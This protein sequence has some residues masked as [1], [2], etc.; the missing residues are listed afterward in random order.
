MVSGTWDVVDLTAAVVLQPVASASSA[1]AVLGTAH[2][3]Q[4]AGHRQLG[5]LG[6]VGQDSP[7]RVGQT[8]LERSLR[9]GS[10]ETEDTVNSVLT[11]VLMDVWLFYTTKTKDSLIHAHRFI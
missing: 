6:E 8:S 5:G 7:G 11:V 1:A 9:L 2:P 3:H 4:A 10:L